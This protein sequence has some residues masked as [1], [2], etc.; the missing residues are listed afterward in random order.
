MEE[1]YHRQGQGEEQ[2]GSVPSCALQHQRCADV[3]HTA[4][5]ERAGRNGENT[6]HPPSAEHCYCALQG[7]GI[8]RDTITCRLWTRFGLSA[9]SGRSGH[10][11]HSGI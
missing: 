4:D 3:D 6:R 7:L 10:E 1:T 9:Q 11:S 5:S 2:R 8:I